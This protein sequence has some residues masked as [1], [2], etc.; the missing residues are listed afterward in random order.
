MRSELEK[1][2]GEKNKAEEMVHQLTKKLELAEQKLADASVCTAAQ[3]LFAR[4]MG[5][6]R[7]DSRGMGWNTWDAMGSGRVRHGWG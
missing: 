1:V 7:M 6:D 3:A 4:N 5:W 2:V